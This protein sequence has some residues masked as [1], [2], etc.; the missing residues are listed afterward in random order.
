MASSHSS[1]CLPDS[2]PFSSPPIQFSLSS[3]LPRHNG[4]FI[5]SPSGWSL[6]MGFFLLLLLLLRYCCWCS[7]ALSLSRSRSQYRRRWWSRISVF[8]NPPLN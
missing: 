7:F 2:P 3:V 6:L 4:C 5:A 8:D 1:T